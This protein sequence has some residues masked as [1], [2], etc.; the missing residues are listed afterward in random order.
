M[1]SAVGIGVA[2]AAGLALYGV[3]AS[4]ALAHGVALP[5]LLLGIPLVYAAAIALFVGW[6]FTLAWIHRAARP[7][8]ARIGV[9]ATLALIGGEYAALF[10]SP[11]RMLFYPLLPRALPASAR[12]LPVVLVHGLLC[13]GGVWWRACRT[14]RAAGV[15]GVHA[16]SYGPP[17]AS[18]EVFAEQLHACIESV[19]RRSGSA[20]V[21]LVT[22]SM[23]GLVAL[24][25]LRRHGGARVR[26]VVAIG[27]PFA[28][29]CLARGL[30]GTAIAQLVPGNPWLDA[31]APRAPQGGPR[32][33]SIWSWHDSLVAPQTSSI[34][35]GADNAALTGIGHNALLRDPQVLARVVEE[36]RREC[37]A[38]RL[39]TVS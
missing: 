30:P 10:G 34:L 22:H 5:W 28:G 29:S 7:P 26:A 23:G 35:R 8:Q 38:M 27:A 31:L 4:P 39:A 15:R 1:W 32:M 16:M 21:M 13:N 3:W 20:Q 18:I 36:I 24:A 2:L 17:L 25:C 37:E 33:V 9:A 11:L 12:D 19:C 14:L 6:Y